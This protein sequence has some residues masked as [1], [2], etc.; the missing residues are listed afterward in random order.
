MRLTDLD[1]NWFTTTEGRH[2]MGITFLCPCCQTQ[3]LGVWFANPIDGLPPATPEC[4]PA[5]RWVR[6]GDTFETM[7]LSP[8]IDV[9]GVGHWHGHIINGEIK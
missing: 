6:T 7:T 5:P 3:H 4:L 1:P 9:S 2:G 8:S